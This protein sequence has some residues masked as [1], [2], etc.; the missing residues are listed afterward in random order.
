[1]CAQDKKKKMIKIQK[2]NL[3]NLTTQRKI[4]FVPLQKYFGK[5]VLRGEKELAKYTITEKQEFESDTPR[6]ANGSQTELIQKQ[7]ACNENKH[8]LPLIL[9]CFCYPDVT[10]NTSGVIT[11]TSHSDLSEPFGIHLY[12][13]GA[14]TEVQR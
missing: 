14:I 2:L 1:M 4:K 13:T 5:N 7:G 8:K 11:E 6:F 3:W 10:Y 12:P 9:P